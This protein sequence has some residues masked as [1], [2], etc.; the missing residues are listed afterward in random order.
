MDSTMHILKKLTIGASILLAVTGTS[1]AKTPG[2]VGKMWN[3]LTDLDFRLLGGLKIAGVSMM[4]APSHLGTPP[5]HKADAICYCADGLNSGWGLGLTY[6]LPAYINDVARQAGCLGFIN[7]TNVMTG[8]ISLS[9]AQD[10]GAV[11]EKRAGATNMQIH[12]AYADVISIAGKSLFE[13][14]GSLAGG[15]KVSYLTEPDF[16]F[17]NDIYSAI[18]S[19]QVSLL[20]AVPLLSQAACGGEAIANTLGAWQDFGICGF[21]STRYP[22]SGTVEST[23]SA[24]VTNMDVTIKYL[25]RASLLGTNLRTYGTD[26]QCKPKYEPFY[27][28]F[29]HRY[30]WSFPTKTSTRYNVDMLMWGMALKDQGASA[31]SFN[32]AFAGSGALTGVDTAPTGSNNDSAATT[33]SGSTP[34][35]GGAAAATESGVS[36]GIIAQAEALLG[37]IPKPLNYPTKEAGFMQVWEAKSCCLVMFTI[38]DLALLIMSMGSSLAAQLAEFYNYAK[39][40]M[41]LYDIYKF[42]DTISSIATTAVVI[43]GLLAGDMA[44]EA[45]NK[46]LAES[47]TY[48]EGEHHVPADSA[49]TPQP[50]ASAPTCP[51][52]TPVC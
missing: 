36:S 12:Y 8:F 49:T 24:Q 41:E 47:A 13:K 33:G 1:F 14:C 51:A 22:L 9:S 18:L 32:S 43:G 11:K 6:W 2:C 26:V 5:K 48:T 50:A 21:G 39:L 17:Q 27:D 45:S 31:S 40:G 35:A 52:S 46:G 25:T 4:E 16:I 20:A 28:P 19:P 10:W 23:N 29:Q 34:A 38:T 3:P 15:L 37:K 7:G 30:Q 44:K 42:V